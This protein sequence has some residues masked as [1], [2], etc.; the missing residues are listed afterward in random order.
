M[1]PVVWVVWALGHGGLWM[2]RRLAVRGRSRAVG[3]GGAVPSWPPGL[4]LAA[5]G[6]GLTAAGGALLVLLTL[7]QWKEGRF[8]D[9]V[10]VTIVAVW[11]ANGV[12]CAGLLLRRAWSGLYAAL[13]CFGWAALLGAQIVDHLVRG[14]PIKEGELVIAIVLISVGVLFGW[15][16]ATSRRIKAFLSVPEG[17]PEVTRALSLL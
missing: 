8:L 15:H 14:S 5:A 1:L 9:L 4:I 13:L 17:G 10:W 12:C 16:L 6:T 11:L 2:V 3:S 7:V